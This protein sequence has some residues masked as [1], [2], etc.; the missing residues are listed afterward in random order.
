[1]VIRHWAFVIKPR[2]SG[3][4]SVFGLGGL[5]VDKLAAD[6]MVVGEL[7]DRARAD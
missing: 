5:L 3:V 7:G 1:L 6:V 4:Q 2:K